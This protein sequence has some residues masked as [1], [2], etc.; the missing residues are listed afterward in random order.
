[1][2][3]ILARIAGVFR[4]AGQGDQPRWSIGCTAPRQRQNVP[5]GMRM[6]PDEDLIR[7]FNVWERLLYSNE[8]GPVSWT[9]SAGLIADMACL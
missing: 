4:G 3:T 8:P 2:K 5:L 7:I 9:G 1:M 6:F